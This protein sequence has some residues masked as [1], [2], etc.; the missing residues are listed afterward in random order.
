MSCVCGYATLST[1]STAL[2]ESRT[3]SPEAVSCG[4]VPQV[5]FTIFY[6][7]EDDRPRKVNRYFIRDALQDAVDAIARGS[8]IEDSPRPEEETASPGEGNPKRAE[9]AEPAGAVPRLDH[10]TKDVA[11]MP[12]IAATIFR[13][14]EKCGIFVADVTFIAQTS[15]GGGG[16][17]DPKLVPNPNVMLEAGY[18]LARIGADRMICVMNE[19]F[20]PAS[21]MPFD[22]AHRRRP[23]AYAL[24]SA[25]NREESKRARKG[26]A[27]ALEEAIRSIM[28]SSPLRTVDRQRR[29]LLVNIIR[30]PDEVVRQLAKTVGA[31]LPTHLRSE[32][33]LLGGDLTGKGL[34]LL[35]RDAG[36]EDLAETAQEEVAL[37]EVSDAY[38]R[39]RAAAQA[40]DQ[41]AFSKIHNPTSGIADGYSEL[42][43]TAAILIAAGEP[44]DQVHAYVVRGSPFRP[45]VDACTRSHECVREDEAFAAALEAAAEAAD[46]CRDSVANVRAL[47]SAPK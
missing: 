9:D 29:R 45:T 37:N 13:K 22:L 6:A 23:I 42:L 1:C 41:C 3:R 36:V 14:I 44:V 27:D 31:T 33:L 43:A 26:L 21:R 5:E 25:E 40:L 8:A 10:D 28:K 20:G 34:I 7:W 11:G 30:D 19:A 16:A 32:F 39:F 35:L 46:A 24:A 4:S 18:A 17:G 38:S 12:E 2:V 15:S 47:L